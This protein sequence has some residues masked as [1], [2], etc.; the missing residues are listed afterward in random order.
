MLIELG[1]DPVEAWAHDLWQCPLVCGTRV[2]VVDP[3]RPVGCK[4]EPPWI[5]LISVHPT[6]AQGF[7]SKRLAIY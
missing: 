4:V 3:L 7:Q 1:S 6:G 5:L 2:L